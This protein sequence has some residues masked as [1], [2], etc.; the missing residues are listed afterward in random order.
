[1]KLII[2]L[3]N[4]G[5]QYKNNRHNAGHMVIDELQPSTRIRGLII[6]KSDSFMNNSGFFVKKQLSKYPS[7]STSDLYII[8]DDLDIPLGAFK[9]QFG[10]GPKGHNGIINIEEKLGTCDFWRVRVG[11]ENRMKNEELRIKGEE[12]VLQDFT[13]EEK[14][15]LNGVIKQICNQ[16]AL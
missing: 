7:V 10:K 13:E 6:K 3:G 2:G 11:V 5:V 4:P 1:M 15:I 16:L 14:I 9:I 12:Y 8:H